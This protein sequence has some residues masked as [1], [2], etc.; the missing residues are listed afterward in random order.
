MNAFITSRTRESRTRSTHPHYNTDRLGEWEILE[1][2]GKG[3]WSIVHAARPCNCPSDQPADYAIKIARGATAQQRQADHLLRREAM[4]GQ[5]LAHPNLVAVL[6]SQTEQSPCFLVMPRLAG[7]TL[8]TT[9]DE[10]GPLSTPHALWIA[11][12]TASA[13]QAMHQAGWLHA[14]VKPGNIHISPEGH[15]TLLDLGFALRLDTSECATTELRGTMRY[16][17]PEMLSSATTVDRP[18]DIYSLGMTLFEMLTGHPPFLDRDL[19]KL[20]RAHLQDPIPNPRSKV[21]DLCPRVHKLLREMLAKQPLR[22]PSTDELID[23]FVQLEIATLEE[24]VS[25]AVA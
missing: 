13:L 10:F 24:R 19:A 1:S 15:V 9:L 17:A 14:D 12:Q 20:F 16:T 5:Q 25:Q 6:A 21:P 18:S 22:R 2:L 23:R 7:V 8:R 3:E 11:R 4:L